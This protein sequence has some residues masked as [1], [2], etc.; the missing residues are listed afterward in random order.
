MR[1][2]IIALAIKELLAILRDPRGRMVLVLPPIVQLLVFAFA[3]TLEVKNVNMAVLNQDRGKWS[4][5]LVQRFVGSPTFR[6]VAYLE[7]VADIRRRIDRSEAIMV[8]HIPQ[9]FSAD[10]E[11]RRPAAVQIVL[12]GR[13]SNAAQIVL[14]Y[15]TRIVNGL[16][17]EIALAQGRSGP[18]SILVAR[19]WFNPNLEYQ[20]FTVPSLIGMITLLVGLAVTALSVAR[21]RELGTFDQLLV[22]PLQPWEIL[23]GKTVPSLLIGLFHATLYFA[24]AVLA[25][26]VPFTGSALLLYVSMVIYLISVIGVGL[27][28]SSLAQT[29]QQAFLGAFMF[30]APAILLSGFASPVENMPD[31]LQHLTIVNPLRHFLVIV[32]GLF[33]K[34][35]PVGTVAANT[36]PLV[37]IAIFTMT[38]ASWLFRRRME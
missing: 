4:F 30:A 9:T 10:I 27:F 11:A 14:G 2:R 31:W 1:T 37:L 16:D 28:I 33:T 20:W 6:R 24:A 23:I 15:A 8:L 3:A 5:E 17:R 18:S 29:Q 25:F 12:D 34:D 21:E 36:L 7:S 19:N 35:M 22:S 32:N 13:R 26:R 38:T